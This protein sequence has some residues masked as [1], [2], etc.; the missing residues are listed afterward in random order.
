MQLICQSDFLKIFLTFLLFQYSF[1]VSVK[2]MCIPMVP[3]RGNNYKKNPTI[4]P[5]HARSGSPHH[6]GK[7]TSWVRQ[8]P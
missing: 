8:K 3:F 6:S 4:I 1:P 5:G 7:V 2:Y